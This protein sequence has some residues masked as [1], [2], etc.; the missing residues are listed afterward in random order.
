MAKWLHKSVDQEA[1]AAGRARH[2]DDSAA[3]VTVLEASARRTGVVIQVEP[4]SPHAVRLS[5]SKQPADRYRAAFELDPGDV[6]DS[7]QLGPALQ[8]TDAVTAYTE[9]SLDRTGAGA[10]GRIRLNV[11]EIFP[12]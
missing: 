4:T 12:D 3:A 2:G 1:N 6:F 11:T 7:T 8:P 5:F 10:D 9:G